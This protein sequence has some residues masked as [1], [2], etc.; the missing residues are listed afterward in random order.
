MIMCVLNSVAKDETKACRSARGSYMWS[1]PDA[2]AGN[3]QIGQ[4]VTFYTR[5][6]VYRNGTQVANRNSNH[7]AVCR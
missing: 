4:C 3:I 6:T 7:V 5:V 2:Y 1:A